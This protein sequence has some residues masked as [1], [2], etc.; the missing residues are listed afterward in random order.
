MAEALHSLCYWVYTKQCFPTFLY[1]RS[2]SQS[3]PS[4]PVWLLSVSVWI[5]FEPRL[6]FHDLCP[7]VSLTSKLSSKCIHAH[8]HKTLAQMPTPET[9]LKRE[10]WKFCNKLTAIGLQST[11]VTLHWLAQFNSTNV[12]FLR[13]L[14]LLKCYTNLTAVEILL[15]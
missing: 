13:P 7:K 11:S 10:W 5:L 6:S 14:H 2:W 1:N 3:P 9:S 15:K 8:L 12:Y 4:V